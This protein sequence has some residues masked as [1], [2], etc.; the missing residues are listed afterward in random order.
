MMGRLDFRSGATF[1]FVEGGEAKTETR[2]LGKF[3]RSAGQ[4]RPGEVVK[5]CLETYAGTDLHK[6][7]YG[8]RPGRSA[9][10]AVRDGSASGG[11]RFN[12]WGA[13]RRCAE[14]LTGI[15]LGSCS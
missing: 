12:D 9:T 13:R 8:Y 5:R 4:N 10:M 11:G 15:G 2:T 7:S 14:L 1:L 6:D 3:Q